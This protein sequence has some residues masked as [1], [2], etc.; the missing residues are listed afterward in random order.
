MTEHNHT[1][2]TQGEA[3]NDD[4]LEQAKWGVDWVRVNEFADRISEVTMIWGSFAQAALFAS[5]L[6]AEGIN[7]TGICRYG[8]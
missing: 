8:E 4:L 5:K 1:H 7:V 2:P 3:I 6:A